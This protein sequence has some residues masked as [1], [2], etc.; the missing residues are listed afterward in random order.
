MNLLTELF[1]LSLGFE[2]YPCNHSGHFTLPIQGGYLYLRP[3]YKGG[4]Y[5]GICENREKM[6]NPKEF[7]GALPLQT[8][9]QLVNLIDAM[10][11]QPIET[12]TEELTQA[13]QKIADWEMPES[14][15][16]WDD[17]KTRPMSYEAAYGSN[18]VRDYIK[19]IA[20]QALQAK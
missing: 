16:F 1:I 20:K 7:D 11:L 17:E 14:G 18:G 10:Q 3:S 4:W 19:E 2:G 8:E 12:K 5:W 6:D 9:D 13:L 15:S